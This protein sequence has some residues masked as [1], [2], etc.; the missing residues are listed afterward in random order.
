MTVF[1]SAFPR[2]KEMIVNQASE[3]EK[4]TNKNKELQ[5]ELSESKS[6]VM[7]LKIEIEELKEERDRSNVLI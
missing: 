3:V 7:K 6:L 5:I 1:F 2:Y 4:L